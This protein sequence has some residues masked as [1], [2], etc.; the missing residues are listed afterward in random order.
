MQFPGQRGSGR[1]SA[2]AAP[3]R[4]GDLPA[5]F[6]LRVSAPL[7][8]L[9]G[10][11]LLPP[12]C[13]QTLDTGG[14]LKVR[15]Q[16]ADYPSDSVFESLTG[17]SSA[18]L[19]LSFR[20]NLGVSF[21][22][23]EARAEY[24]I[25]AVYGDTVE[26]TR[27][28]PDVPLIPE[29]LPDDDRRFFNLTHVV[30][31]VDKR[32]ALHRLDRLAVGVTTPNAVIRLGRQA[33]SWGNGMLFTPMDFFNPFD[34]AAI[35]KEYKT[36]DDMLYGQYLQSNGNDLQGVWV[37]RR[38]ELGKATSRVDSMAIKYHGFVSNAEYDFLVAR[39]YEDLVLGGGGSFNIGGGVL[40]GD[41][42]LTRTESDTMFSGVASYTCSW[43][44]WN[45][46]IN[47]VAEVFYNGFGQPD[48]DYR[49][50]SLLRNQD[51]LDR[52][53]RGELF[54]LG[55]EYLAISAMVEMNP[56]WGLI[57]NAFVNLSDGSALIQVVSRHDV[58]QDWQILAALNLPMGSRGSEYGG[59][60]I[61]KGEDGEP[62]Y[63]TTNWGF[64]LQ[65]AWYF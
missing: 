46:N 7:H 47:G 42:M 53:A 60:E 14:H 3:V 5:R 1:G 64:T 41:L 65:L 50:E 18:D 4:A 43:N 25:Q 59:I 38:D 34:P 19:A 2:P 52:I 22:G 32:A 23:W 10:L 54:T 17:R 8:L 37:L 49:P 56:L 26:F 27:D 28:L 24:Q 16:T 31:D 62:V 63:L 44:W 33:V 20:Y 12:L 11:F 35:D 61:G 13:A 45:R 30:T 6:L 58:A 57:P 9:A 21:E 15:L 55:R 51:L 36:G 48:G 29:R 39:H 40:R